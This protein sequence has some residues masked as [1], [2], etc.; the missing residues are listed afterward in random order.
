[1]DFVKI[2]TDS[3][4]RENHDNDSNKSG[5]LFKSNMLIYNNE[6]LDAVQEFNILE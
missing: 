3:Q 2:K 1:M 4:H 6:P 5:R